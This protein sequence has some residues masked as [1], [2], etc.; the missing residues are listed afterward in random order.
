MFS[1]DN[2]Q[3]PDNPDEEW[4]LADLIHLITAEVETA[5]DKL[6][7]RSHNRRLM[8]YVK[9][10]SLDLQVTVRHN[11]Q[12][13]LL[14]RNASQWQSNVS[15]L[16]L[17]FG[18]LLDTQAQEIR[19]SE[20]IDKKELRP[21]ELLS[22]IDRSDIETLNKFS[23]NSIA[24]LERSTQTPSMLTELSQVTGIDEARI[25]AWRQWPHI[26]TVQPEQG[27]PGSIVVINGGKFNKGRIETGKIRVLFQNQPLVIDKDISTETRLTVEIPK[28]ATGTGE[29]IVEVNGE[30][31]NAKTWTVELSDLAVEDI[32]LNLNPTKPWNILNPSKPGAIA[33]Q[34]KVANRGKADAEGFNIRWELTLPDESTPESQEQ[35]CPKLIAGEEIRTKPIEFVCQ[36]SGTYTVKCTA[37]PDGKIPDCSHT[38][39]TFVKQFVVPA[40]ML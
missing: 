33:F 17:E 30:A 25:R 31:T 4:E 24:D 38:N 9:N 35:S 14:F 34:A 20:A 15:T 29:L 3:P 22:D 19:K 1:D 23:I 16:K 11:S 26:T 8:M 6:W 12:G 27:P 37:D 21:L 28:S 18:Y 7:V 32:I 36:Q 10:L 40:S 5:K 13:K 39:Q 2:S